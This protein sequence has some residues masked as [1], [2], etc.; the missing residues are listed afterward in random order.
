M[1]NKVYVAESIQFLLL[2]EQQE[3]FFLNLWFFFAN[4]S[5]FSLHKLLNLDFAYKSG[6]SL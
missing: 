6:L 3:K 5:I 2:N 1:C 4:S